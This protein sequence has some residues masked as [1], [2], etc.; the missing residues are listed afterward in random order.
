MAK[1]HGDVFGEDENVFGEV[2]GED[3]EEDLYELTDGP[4]VEDVLVSA[5][6]GKI[7]TLSNL[8]ERQNCHDT[9]EKRHRQRE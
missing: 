6:L 9:L 2:F 1:V 3:E 7:D 4:L 8:K 5:K